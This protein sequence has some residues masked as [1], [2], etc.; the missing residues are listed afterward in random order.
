MKKVTLLTD[1]KYRRQVLLHLR[2]LGVLHPRLVDR[3]VSEDIQKTEAEL[4]KLEKALLLIGPAAG[5][6]K[7][8]KSIDVESV[9]DTI[10]DLAGKKDRFARELEKLEE[11]NGWFER[12]GS[13]SL[14]SLQ[15]L[16]NSELY[17]RFFI[18]D[19][20]ELEKLDS[21]AM[22]QVIREEQNAVR[23]VQI[24]RSPDELLNLKQDPMPEI[25]Y[26]YLQSEL[27]RLRDEIRTIDQ[28]LS[29]MSAAESDLQVQ[30]HK[31]KR[32]LEFNTV[33]ASM[34][35]SESIIYL[36]GYC[37]A[38]AVADIEKLAKEEGLGL[39]FEDP[40]SPDQ[41]P[42]LLRNPKWLRIIQPLFNFMGTLPG[43]A[44]QDISFVFLAFFSIFYAMLVGDAGYGLILLTGTFYFSRKKKT[45]PREFFR[46]MYVLSFATILWGLF[47]G[48]WFGS[49]R[50]SQLPVLRWFIIENIYSF[51]D[52]NQETLMQLTF[53]IGAVHLSVGRLL[54]AIKRI[55][56]PTAIAEI[57]W[58][59]VLWAIYFVANSLVLGKEM[60]AFTG[61]LFLIGVVLIAVF[62]NF[63]K[64]I[65]KGILTSLA[66]LPLS[67]I[68]SFSDV[69]SYIRLF[70]VGM[71]TVI[72]ASSFN[73]MAVGAGIHSVLGGIIA[74]LVLFLG[75]A[76]NITLAMMSV[77]VHGVRL[78]M[79]EFSNHIGM[80]WTGKKY[81]PFSNS[82]E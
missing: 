63:Q 31:L 23:F 5:E 48:T 29:Q 51:S 81:D 82:H 21:D 77:L 45:A 46:L 40:D 32:T 68:N 72:V 66:N 56:S 61:T 34:S 16:E 55:N 28:T 7:S 47:S 6:Q 70:A 76:L 30:R 19:K 24:A 14:A 8:K 39:I 49:E 11:M 13:V 17:C 3:P 60:P 80:Q 69:V 20:S 44:E 59:V 54:A 36:Q 27:E 4:E 33:D 64:N 18:T 58:I 75:H 1:V 50:L 62:A 38:E 25:E 12:W 73:D 57:G 74:I 35:G 41:V 65:F 52:L 78:N 15:E 37:P 53:I 43:Y 71:A 79:L 10:L 22:I 26:D 42:T 2:E 9:V 67:I